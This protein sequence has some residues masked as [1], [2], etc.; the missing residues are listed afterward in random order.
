ML[1]IH[2]TDKYIKKYTTVSSTSCTIP[3]Q[4]IEMKFSFRPPCSAFSHWK[5]A[6]PMEHALKYPVKACN[7]PWMPYP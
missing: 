4:G 7:Q 3:S 5:A 6:P 2:S 1:Q